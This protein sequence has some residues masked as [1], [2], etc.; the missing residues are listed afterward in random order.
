MKNKSKD[1]EQL[2]YDLLYENKKLKETIK[3]QED[4][5]LF[6][7]KDNKV[8]EIR[9]EILEELKKYKNRSKK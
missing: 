5:L 2:Y 7:K 6:I 8:L 3:Q 1:Y 9:K 4:E